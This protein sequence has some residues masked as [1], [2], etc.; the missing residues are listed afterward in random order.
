M[1]LDF[2]EVGEAGIKEVIENARYPN[3]CI[4]PEVK[5]IEGR[6]IGKWH[7]DQPLNITDQADAE[8]RRLFAA[9]K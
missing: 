6:D 3:R 8:Y 1:V 9:D 4:A 5:K 7:D 2:D